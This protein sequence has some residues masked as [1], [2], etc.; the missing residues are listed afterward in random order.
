MATFYIESLFTNIQVNETIN[1]AAELAF[2]TDIQSYHAWITKLQRT[3][4]LKLC[5]QDIFCL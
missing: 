3:N 5:T 2:T 4:Q 1:I